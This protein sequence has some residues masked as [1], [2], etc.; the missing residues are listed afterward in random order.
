MVDM[1]VWSEYGF[2]AAVAPLDS[3]GACWGTAL[4]IYFA[5]IA[6]SCTTRNPMHSVL[7]SMAYKSPAAIF[8][9]RGGGGGR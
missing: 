2:R 8:R 1:V 5:V 9:P 7:S 3:L 6:R 4:I